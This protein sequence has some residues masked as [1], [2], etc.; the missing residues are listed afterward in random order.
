M[1]NP[2]DPNTG[3][4]PT[5]ESRVETLERLVALLQKEVALKRR[6]KP[7]RP[8]GEVGQVPIDDYQHPELAP[9]PGLEAL[10]A[11]AASR[12]APRPSRPTPLVSVSP[13]AV[14]RAR[15]SEAV[16]AEARIG[17][18]DQLPAVAVAAEA[19]GETAHQP[20]AFAARAP[21]GEADQDGPTRIEATPTSRRCLG[22]PRAAERAPSVT[23]H[24]RRDP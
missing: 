17:E 4:A 2:I 16:A 9:R 10:E 7:P 22:H 3:L 23:G 1:P 15:V 21:V 14:A 8:E 24:H 18:A 6:R 11:L 5:L 20:L 13:P 12:P 19:V